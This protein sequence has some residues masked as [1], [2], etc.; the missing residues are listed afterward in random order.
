MLQFSLRVQDLN[1]SIV[2]LVF[3]PGMDFILL[4]R[5]CIWMDRCWIS[6]Y[7]S[8][9]MHLLEKFAMLALIVIYRLYSLVVSWIAFLP[10]VAST[11]LSGLWELVFRKETPRSVAAQFLWKVCLKRV[12]SSANR[13]TLKLLG[14]NQGQLPKPVLFGE[15]P[16]LTFNSLS[17]H[18][19]AYALLVSEAVIVPFPCPLE[20][21]VGFSKR[22]GRSASAG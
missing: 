11:A 16:M 19:W 10:L 21:D 4:S 7:I 1:P 20:I 9:T 3:I 13:F 18:F 15:S 17:A 8:A 5:P 22:W 12:M 2:G 14:G 6:P